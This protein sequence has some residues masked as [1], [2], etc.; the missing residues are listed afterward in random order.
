MPR[1][2]PELS[3]HSRL[4]IQSAENAAAIG[5]LGSRVTGVESTLSHVQDKVMS[6]DSKVAS[7]FSTIESLIRE[8]KASQGPGLPDILKGVA[9]GGAIIAMSAGAITM[10]VTS[11]VKPDLVALQQVTDNLRTR[12]DARR[13]AERRELLDMKEER[14]KQINQAIEKLSDQ[15]LRLNGAWTTETKR[16][17]G[18]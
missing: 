3:D 9:T 1:S 17:G 7:G 4:V 6:L 12:E 14:Q 5:V 10:L 16:G 18:S 13:E 2:N 15:A 8:N 11:F